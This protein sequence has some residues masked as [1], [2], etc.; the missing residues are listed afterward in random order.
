MS[1]PINDEIL[2]GL[3][4]AV[5]PGSAAARMYRE[6]A[7]A[8][9]AAGRADVEALRDEIATLLDKVPDVTE[10]HRHTATCA[11]TNIRCLAERIRNIF[12]ME[13]WH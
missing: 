1:Q 6:R 7:D 11:T 10:R 12:G 9:R 5:R 8:E 4:A 2:A 3:Y 13:E